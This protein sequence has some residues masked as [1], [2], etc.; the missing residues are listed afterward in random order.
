MNA[1]EIARR[2]NVLPEQFGTRVSP[3]TLR[4]LMEIRG[5]G[6]YGGSSLSYRLHSP[7]T[8]PL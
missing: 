5:G 4:S 1:Y 3:Q 6:E 2:A 7:R 8:E